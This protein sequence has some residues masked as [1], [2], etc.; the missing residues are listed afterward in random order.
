MSILSRKCAGPLLLLP[1]AAVLSAAEDGGHGRDAKGLYAQFCA[2]CHG[3]DMA[4]GKGPSLIKADWNDSGVRAAMTCK[5][6]EGYTEGG[7]PSFRATFDDAEALAI[8]NHIRETA[9]RAIDPAPAMERPL[10]SGVQRSELHSYRIEPV[11]AGLDVPWSM[12]FLPDGRMLVTERVGRLRV[13]ENGRLL[14]EPVEGVPKVVV[15]DEA[16]LMSVV[17]DPDFATN[18]WIYL[19]FCD[20]GEGNTAMTKIVRAQLRGNRLEDEETVFAIPRERYPRGYALFG[21]RIV[22]Q[23]DYLFF[24][25]GVRDLENGG[26]WAAQDLTLPSGKIHRV[27]HDGSVP[28]DNPLAGNPGAFASI[29]SYGNRNPHGLA[30]NPATGELW[31]SEHGPRGGDELNHIRP[32]RNYGWPL[33]TNGINYDGTPVTD[34]TAAPGFEQPVI[35]WTPSI[36]VDEIEFYTGDKF[37]RWKNNLFIGS[38]AQQKFL[39]IE[40]DGDRVVHREQVFAGLGRVRDIKT[41]PDGFLYVALE[42]IGKP[43]RIIRLVPAE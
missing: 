27:F 9:T 8:V 5:I 15:R 28:R 11:A 16:G 24:S 40:L 23:G 25:V 26:G 38:L 35:D 2:D 29:W 43:G 12:A 42:F 36:A 6:I 20:P 10:P 1:L 37:P 31:E 41:G 33:I 21:G 22:F 18:G 17:A 39:R 7:M 14:P 19:S 13:I 4:G 32:G 30:I 3:A 34:K